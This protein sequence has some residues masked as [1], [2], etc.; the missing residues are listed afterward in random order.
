MMTALPKP[1]S[2]LDTPTPAMRNAR[3]LAR[4]ETGTLDYCTSLTSELPAKPVRA[5]TPLE[6]MYAYFGSDEASAGAS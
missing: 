4:A 2:F 6:A 3:A 1:H 5:L